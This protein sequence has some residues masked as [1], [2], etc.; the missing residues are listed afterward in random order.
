MR[1]MRIPLKRLL[2]LPLFMLIATTGLA[3]AQEAG[4]SVSASGG[5]E[6]SGRAA[7]IGVGAESFLAGSTVFGDLGF[8]GDF[9][10][11]SAAS[12]VYDA[13]AWRVH[14]LIG[15]DS[16]GDTDFLLGGK[17]FYNLHTGTAA[18][19]A[20]GGGLGLLLDGD[21]DNGMGDDDSVHILLEGGVQLRAFVVPN[22]AIGAMAGLGFVI[23]DED[24]ADDF[25]FLGGQVL[26]N[27]GIWYF[28]D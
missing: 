10:P 5:M 22:V 12:V 4:G 11:T 6:A 26:G 16:A 28:F 13:T 14:G 18:D 21:G 2:P 7:G 8:I 1:A 25:F 19:F 23:Y 15:M 9:F 3:S 20:V 17:F 24:N 27:V